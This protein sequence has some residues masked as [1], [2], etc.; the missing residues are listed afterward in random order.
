[1]SS[2]KITARLQTP[3]DENGERMDIHLITTADEVILDP[4]S[5]NPTTLAERL[6]HLGTIH[7]AN[8]QPEFPCIWAKPTT[9][10]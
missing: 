3:A 10:K 5:D 6:E 8:A 7:I 9:L 2:T 4:D 1:M